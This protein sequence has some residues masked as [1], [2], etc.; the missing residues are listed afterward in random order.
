MSARH[1]GLFRPAVDLILDKRQILLRSRL[2]ADLDAGIAQR[3]HHVVRQDEAVPAEPAQQILAGIAAETAAV[4]AEISH[5]PDLVRG[6]PGGQ[7]LA[8]TAMLFRD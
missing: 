4:L 7:E 1:A 5:Q 8:K 6:R 2:L 3:Q